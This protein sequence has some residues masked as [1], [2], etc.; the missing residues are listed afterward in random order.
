MFLRG[1]RENMREEAV[2]AMI[3]E[4]KPIMQLCVNVEVV[5]FCCERF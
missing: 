4:R 1:L 5:R 3:E 2:K